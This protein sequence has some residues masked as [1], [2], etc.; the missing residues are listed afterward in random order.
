MIRTEETSLDGS[1]HIGA[2]S[3]LAGSQSFLDQL[4]KPR[5]KERRFSALQQFNFLGVVIGSDHGTAKVSQTG[6]PNNSLMPQADYANLHE[7][8]T[9]YPTLRRTAIRTA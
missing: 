7:R 9:L 1:G 5:F 6:R 8:L 4:I 2:E 3:E